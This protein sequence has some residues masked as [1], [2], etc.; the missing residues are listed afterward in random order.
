M[1]FLTSVG[2][3]VFKEDKE[4]IITGTRTTDNYYQMNIVVDTISMTIQVYDIEV[5]C[6]RLSHVNYKL[7]HKFQNKGIV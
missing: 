6:R 1:H 4:C 7:L 2:C 5:R 3:Y